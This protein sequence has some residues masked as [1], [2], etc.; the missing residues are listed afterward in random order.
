MLTAMKSCRV[1][2]VQADNDRPLFRP[3]FFAARVREILKH[4]KYWPSQRTSLLYPRLYKQEGADK[5]NRARRKEE[6]MKSRITRYLLAAAG[7]IGLAGTPA[8]FA[9]DRFGV[10][11]DSHVIARDNAEIRADQARLQE[12]LR[13]GRMTQ[14]ARDRAELRRDQMKRDRDLAA[15]QHDSGGF[16]AHNGYRFGW[17]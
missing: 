5:E 4:C 11:V 10:R 17:R 12:D 15:L 8:I 6:K 7:A 14:V 3:Q 9:A 1:T 13:H 2:E 16:G